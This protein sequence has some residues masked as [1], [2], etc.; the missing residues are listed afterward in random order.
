MATYVWFAKDGSD[1]KIYTW[2]IEDIWKVTN[3]VKSQDELNK[4]ETI[5][6]IWWETA[7]GVMIIIIM[8]CLG[9]IVVNSI[10]WR[11]KTILVILWF[12]TWAI[13]IVMWHTLLIAMWITTLW[14]I[15]LNINDKRE[16][17]K[18]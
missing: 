9:L 11:E 3:F 12:I 2:S 15:I 6:S 5:A 1:L 10:K 17:K 7:I 4:N 18:K 14:L 8:T 16:N 13:N